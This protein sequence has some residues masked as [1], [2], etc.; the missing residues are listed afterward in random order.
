M[1]IKDW[2]ALNK[3]PESTMYAWMARFREEEPELFEKPNAS[4]WIELSRDAIAAQTA[5]ATMP[6]ADDG[7]VE[8]PVSGAMEANVPSAPIIVRVNGA[9]VAVPPGSADAHIASVLKAVAAL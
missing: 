6:A 3:V 4:Q 9:E 2:C 8:A 5:L 7:L 1:T